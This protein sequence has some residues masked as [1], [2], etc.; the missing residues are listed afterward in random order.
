[1]EK[2]MNNKIC[3]ADR[4]KNSQRDSFPSRPRGSHSPFNADL[5]NVSL[6]LS[7][8]ILLEVAT[9]PK[10]GLVTRLG[11]GAHR[12]MSIFTFMMSSAVLGRAFQEILEVGRNHEGDVSEL[13]AEIRRYGVGLEQELLRTTKNVNTQRG[14]LF[15]G[16][17]LAGAAGY[18]AGR[19]L[20]TE[21][22]PEV[23]RQMTAGIVRREL[24][25]LDR[26]AKTYGEKLYARYGITGIR[27]E[28]E[29]GFP[30]VMNKGLPALREAFDRGANINDAQLHGLIALMTVV[31]DSN[32][33]WRSDWETAQ[34]VKLIAGEI[35]HKGSVFTEEGRALIEKACRDF[36][37]RNISPGGCAD[38]LSI[39]IAMYLL[40]N[41]EFPC[42]I[43]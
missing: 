5:L 26:P 15:A 35:L 17:V 33:L 18:A 34:E 19:N 43:I 42:A 40:E 20:P 21:A 24:E 10:P 30:S 1:M 3:T 2:L 8:A 23:V 28:V 38:L 22:L 16:G 37:E 41:K 31:E 9:A 7:Q 32:V 6:Y 14:I 11:N 27:G 4:F 25:S 29:H 13:L 12:D 39:T 36:E